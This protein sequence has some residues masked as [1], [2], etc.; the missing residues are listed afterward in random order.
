MSLVA[1]VY[2]V[3]VARE[4]TSFKGSCPAGLPNGSASFNGEKVYHQ[5]DALHRDS[6]QLPYATGAAS[7]K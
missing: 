3:S 7:A 4:R 1:L 5:F 2:A 6:S